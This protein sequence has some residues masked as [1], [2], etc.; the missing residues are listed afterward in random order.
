MPL[1]GRKG[2][3]RERTAA[4]REAAR[5]ERARRRAERGGQLPPVAGDEALEAGVADEPHAQPPEP[6]P[7]P[8]AAPSPDP[9]EDQTPP[10]SPRWPGRRPSAARS[11]W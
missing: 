4:E 7:E 8:P 3:D 2:E 9:H 10:A 1:F 6:V 5:Q 11:R